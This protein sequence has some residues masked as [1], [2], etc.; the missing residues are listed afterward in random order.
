MASLDPVTRGA[1]LFAI[2]F[3]MVLQDRF[4]DA[5]AACEAHIPQL[6]PADAQNRTALFNVRNVCLLHLR[7]FSGHR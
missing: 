3:Q 1:L 2:P 7:R 6:D 4:T 5:L